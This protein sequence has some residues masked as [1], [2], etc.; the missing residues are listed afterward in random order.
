MTK[1]NT[2]RG[3]LELVIAIIFISLAI[4]NL[5]QDD[6]IGYYFSETIFWIMILGSR[7][8]SKLDDNKNDS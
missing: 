7:V 6:M 4:F 5:W 2:N 8:M 3:G 1:K